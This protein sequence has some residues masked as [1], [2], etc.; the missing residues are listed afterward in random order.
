[1]VAEQTFQTQLVIMVVQVAVLPLVV[2]QVLQHLV[3]VLKVVLVQV[4]DQVM[5]EEA[6]EDLALQ[7]VMVR[8]T[9]VVMEVLELILIL[10]GLMRLKVEIADTTQVVE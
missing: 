3:K 5:V 9:E 10:L 8:N 2:Q 6:V 1:M 4:L 7:E